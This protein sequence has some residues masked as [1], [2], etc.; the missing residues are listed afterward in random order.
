MRT[1]NEEDYDGGRA[2]NDGVIVAVVS[3]VVVRGDGIVVAA[4]LRVAW[5][6]R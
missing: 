6:S 1:D 4:G 3:A 5:Y 2:T